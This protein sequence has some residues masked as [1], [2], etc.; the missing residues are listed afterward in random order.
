MML[1]PGVVDELGDVC[2]ERFEP[3]SLVE[4]LNLAE[5]LLRAPTNCT[6]W[7]SSTVSP[8]IVGAEKGSVLWD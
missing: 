4:M 5:G 7:S 2:W 8:V 1:L 3:V 6:A